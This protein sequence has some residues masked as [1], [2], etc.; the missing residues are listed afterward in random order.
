MLGEKKIKKILEKALLSSS[1][2][3]TEVL[4]ILFDSKLSRFANSVIHQNMAEYNAIFFTRAAI[5]KK[6]G[7]SSSSGFDMERMKKTVWRACENARQQKENPDFFGFPHPA[8]FHKISS[9]DE[10]TAKLSPEKMASLIKII[11][12]KADSAGAT[13][14][15]AFWVQF[16]EMAVMNSNG[17]FCYFP[18]TSVS[19]TT[20]ITRGEYTGYSEDSARAVRNVDFEAVA[21]EAIE[22]SA[23]LNHIAEIEPGEYTIVAEEYAIATMLEHLSSMSFTATSVEEGKS[24]LAGNWGK[25]VVGE[26]IS[27]WD[28]GFDARGFVLPFDFEGIPKKRVNF[29]RDGKAVGVVYDHYYASKEGKTSTGHAV[30][31]NPEYNE[32]LPMNIFMNSGDSSLEDMIRSTERGLLIKRFD[33]IREVHPLKTMI[34]GMTRDGVF[35]IEKGEKVARVK[36]LRFTQSIADALSCVEKISLGRKLV[37]GRENYANVP[38]SLVVP[39]LKIGSFNFTGKTTF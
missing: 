22:A 2:D 26:N 20:V 16:Q 35:L 6:V 39:K 8:P 21:D 11:T 18:S 15:G 38:S 23:S 37:M 5:G 25:K 9:V 7:A 31:P 29:I 10:E 4:I 3:Q 17:I 30:P 28:D 27:I 36:N 24:F 19:I 34:T 33:Y 12:D 14:S 13:A 1:A 32:P